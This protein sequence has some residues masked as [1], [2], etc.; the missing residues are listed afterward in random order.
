MDM[1]RVQRRVRRAA[2][3][4][5]TW[6]QLLVRHMMVPAGMSRW[7]LGQIHTDGLTVRQDVQME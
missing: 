3:S 1:E 4:C 7:Q 6:R 2:G 5:G